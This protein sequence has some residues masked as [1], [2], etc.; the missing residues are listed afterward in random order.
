MLTALTM[1]QRNFQVFAISSFSMISMM[2]WVYI[3]MY[4]VSALM[5]EVMER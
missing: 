4:I 5:T 2:G 1:L 3:P